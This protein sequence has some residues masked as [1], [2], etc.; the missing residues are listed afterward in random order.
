MRVYFMTV[1][2]LQ[3]TL[4]VY[5]ALAEYW[6]VPREYSLAVDVLL[7]GRQRPEKLFFDLQNLRYSRMSK[8]RTNTHTQLFYKEKSVFL[9]PIIFFF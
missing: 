8:V 9:C 7:P 3:A 5:K 6:A 4:L 1:L 2:L